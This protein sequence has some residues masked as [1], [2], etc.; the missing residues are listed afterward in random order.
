MNGGA[1]DAADEVEV[2]PEGPV[3]HPLAIELRLELG[4]KRHVIPT[5][6][7][8]ALV[9]EMTSYGLVGELEFVVKD[10]RRN[11]FVD[12]VLPDFPSD[13]PGEVQL[14]I[15]AAYWDS[16]LER[17][18]PISTRGLIVRRWLSEHRND[19]QLRQPTIMFRRYGIAF[20]DPAAVVWSQH[21][22]IALFTKKTL[23]AAID[24]HRGRDVKLTYDWP[25]LKAQ[26]PLICLPLDRERGVSFRDFVSWVV[27]RYNGVL[28]YKHDRGQYVLSGDRPAGK[29]PEPLH[30]DDVAEMMTL[31]PEI[32]RRTTRVVNADATRSGFTKVSNKQA[33]GGLYGDV[34]VRSA[35][36]KRVD[37]R[38]ALERGRALQAKREL[39]IRFARYPTVSVMP[40]SL[41]D[42]STRGGFARNRMKAPEP[43][44]VHR[45][46]LEAHALEQGH[47]THYNHPTAG[48]TFD[49][50]AALETKGETVIRLPDW[51]APEWPIQVEG[52]VVSEIG[53]KP[54]LTYQIAQDKKTSQDS[55]TVELPLFAKQKVSAPFEPY[56]G[57]GMFYIP[58]YKDAK[59]LVSLGYDEAHIARLLDW[60]PGARVPMDG[61]GQHLLLGKSATS[62]T[63][64]L[65]DYQ[66]DRPVF[67]IKRT[68][69]K[70]T[71]VLR[72]SEGQ[73][74]LQVKESK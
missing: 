40:G 59:V 9:M 48:F 55:Y 53:K 24:A 36:Q 12:E 19:A 28:T 34:M 44:R 60:R 39:Q 62:N 4:G 47:D 63:S 23:Q 22:P 33:I 71:A 64:M 54:E 68:N 20:A 65:H 58:A 1:T 50:R 13:K 35:V 52:K 17:P 21:F 41:I 15:E 37:D 18:P 69:K 7:I 30:R 29:K 43:W 8:K 25:V 16:G 27:D 51:Q 49:L 70:D 74:F 31:F 5:G 72:I 11:G 61:Q 26:R 56:Q 67:Q 32:T 45:L 42:V 57:S 14:T 2:E 6:N 46:S 3:I 73:L 66:G 38:V 10:D